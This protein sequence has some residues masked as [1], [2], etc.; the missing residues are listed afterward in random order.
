MKSTIFIHGKGEDQEFD[1]V[2]CNSSLFE[3]QGKEAKAETKR[4]QFLKVATQPT[5]IGIEECEIQLSMM[6]TRD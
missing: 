6:Q 4:G 5:L 2:R 1:P 3:L